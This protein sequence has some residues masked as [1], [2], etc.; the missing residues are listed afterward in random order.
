MSSFLHGYHVRA[1]GVRL[2]LLRYGGQGPRMLLLPGITSPAVT[3]GFVAGRLARHFDVHVLDFRGRGLSSSAPGMDASLDAMAADVLDLMEVQG[4]SSVTLLGHSM[5]ARV[6]IRAAARDAGRIGR[7][8]LVDPPVSGPGRRAYPVPLPWYVDSIRMAVHGITADALRPYAPSWTDEQLQL[9]AEWLH[10]CSE[11]AV[12]QAHAGFHDDDIHADLAKLQ[13]PGLLMT[14]GQG[15][16]V[17]AEDLAEIGAL[18]PCLQQCTVPGAGHMIP[19][20][21]EEGFH[22]VLGAYL[23]VDLP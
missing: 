12:I 3:W 22:R 18:A 16:V 1:N 10:T 20:D 17:L 7:L 9:R 2:H 19:W 13:T 5:G 14:A 4:W 23:K 8:L 11:E 21:D 6:A 15:G